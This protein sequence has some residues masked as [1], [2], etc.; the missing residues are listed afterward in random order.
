MGWESPRDVYINIYLYIYI[1]RYIWGQKHT[2]HLQ[3]V[4]NR[5][6]HLYIHLWCES[7]LNNSSSIRKQEARLSGGDLICR[8]GFWKVQLTAKTHKHIWTWDNNNNYILYQTM[9]AETGHLILWKQKT[10]SVQEFF[11]FT[12]ELG[13]AFARPSSIVDCTLV[14]AISRNFLQHKRRDQRA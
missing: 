2:Q 12:I 6:A 13:L 4:L 10:A 11:F 14:S 5:N 7:K 9:A 3:T 8:A 1:Y